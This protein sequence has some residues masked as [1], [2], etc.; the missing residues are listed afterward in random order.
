MDS[1]LPDQLRSELLKL[2][3]RLKTLRHSQGWTLEELSQ[4]VDISEAYLS[5][6]ESGERQP[7]LAVLF[8]LARAYDLSLTELFQPAPANQQAIASE[9]GVFAGAI[10]RAGDRILQKGNGLLYASL[11]GGGSLA[12]LHPLR[13][14]VPAN[15][16]GQTLYQHAGEEWLYVLSGHITLVLANKEYVLHPGDV[17]HFNASIP[18]RLSAHSQ[19]DAEIILVACASSRSLLKSYF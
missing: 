8:N 18:H 3:D 5:R 17:A 2:G 13:I 6:L 15:R 12:D 1:A 10:I 7:S 14:I 11:S 16:Q 4:Y 19:Q 9:Q